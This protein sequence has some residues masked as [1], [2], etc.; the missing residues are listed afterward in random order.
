M[1]CACGRRTFFLGGSGINSWGTISPISTTPLRQRRPPTGPVRLVTCSAGG[2]PVALQHFAALE[3]ATKSRKV[4]RIFLHAYAANPAQI[5]STSSTSA[6]FLVSTTLMLWPI[7]IA[8]DAI[9][10]WLI[11]L[12]LRN[13]DHHRRHRSL[14]RSHIKNG[15]S[16]QFCCSFEP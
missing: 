13:S 7:M 1:G 8:T 3:R 10:G 9:N 4:A 16:Q 6:S 12:L 2:D 5:A 14:Y 11:G 15:P